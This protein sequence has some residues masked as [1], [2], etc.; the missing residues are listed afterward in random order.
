M[1]SC[2]TFL[3]GNGAAAALKMC[4]A[5]DAKR[6]R[7]LE[8]PLDPGVR[9]VRMRPTP[10]MIWRANPTSGRLECRWAVERGTATDED[11][12]CNNPLRKAA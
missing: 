10:R 4:R 9:H 2:L 7:R 11:V 1:K 12:S 5:N 6:D 8:T 3:R